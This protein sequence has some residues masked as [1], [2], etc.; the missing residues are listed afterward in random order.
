MLPA[1]PTVR[2][3]LRRIA[4]TFARARPTEVMPRRK[5]RLS[6]RFSRNVEQTPGCWNWIGA[7]TGSGY[8][9]LSVEGRAVPAHRVAWL[10]ANGPVGP[11]ERIFHACGN[12]LCVRPEHLELVR[13][14]G[15]IPISPSRAP[16]TNEP[17]VNLARTG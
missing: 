17:R 10:L 16:E 8:G 1:R 5:I 2:A 14:E 4:E 11:D 3:T 13:T 15:A 7:R 12:R 6:S 9:A